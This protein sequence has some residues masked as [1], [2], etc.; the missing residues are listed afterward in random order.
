MRQFKRDERLERQ[1][2]KTERS[3][4]PHSHVVDGLRNVCKLVKVFYRYLVMDKAIRKIEKEN[5]KEGKD[6]KKLEKADKKRDKVCDLGKKVMKQKKL[7]T[8]KATKK[9]KK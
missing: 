9:G 8:M 5:K 1:I 7:K 3:L 6:L 2:N 4:L